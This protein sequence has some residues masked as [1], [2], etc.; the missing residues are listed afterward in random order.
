MART[1]GC[2]FGPFVIVGRAV[3]NPTTLVEFGENGWVS[4]AAP[5]EVWCTSRGSLRFPTVD[6]LPLSMI[7]AEVSRH[8]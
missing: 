3:I 8:F 7:A 2:G 4:A 5:T 1:H 6:D